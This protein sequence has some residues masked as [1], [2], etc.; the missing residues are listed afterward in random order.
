MESCTLAWEGPMG[1]VLPNLSLRT[2]I[3]AVIGENQGFYPPEISNTADFPD[4]ENVLNKRHIK[5]SSELND[6]RVENNS[7]IFKEGNQKGE[8]AK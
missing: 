4:W 8:R 7:L 2:K 5:N 6:I 1:K 3:Y